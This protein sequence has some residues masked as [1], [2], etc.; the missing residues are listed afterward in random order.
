MIDHCGN[1]ILH[2]ACQS[3]SHEAAQYLLICGADGSLQNSDG[4][5]PFS[6]VIEKGH[7]SIAQLLL[8]KRE[9]YNKTLD[10]RQVTMLHSCMQ[11]RND[12]YRPAFTGSW[13][14]S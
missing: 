2:D 8:E 4:D 7:Q 13:S 14:Q 11:L 3:D 9:S 1:T 12:K 6:L 5:T 10:E